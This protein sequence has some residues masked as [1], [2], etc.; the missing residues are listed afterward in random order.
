MKSRYDFQSV[1]SKHR[2]T[3]MQQDS[4]EALHQ[5]W[6]ILV[7]EAC[8]SSLARVQRNPPSTVINEVASWCVEYAQGLYRNWFKDVAGTEVNVLLHHAG[9]CHLC[10]CTCLMSGS[11]NIRLG[12]L[13]CNSDIPTCSNPRSTTVTAFIFHLSTAWL[14]QQNSPREEHPLYE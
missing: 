2:Q 13:A 8:L 14:C 6:D 5:Y 10:C 3:V 11:I 4:I 7:Q 9:S 12:Q 1:L